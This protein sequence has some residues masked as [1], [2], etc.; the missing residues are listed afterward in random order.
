MFDRVCVCECGGERGV[1]CP[2][3]LMTDASIFV[4]MGIAKRAI[5]KHSRTQNTHTH[6]QKPR[7]YRCCCSL[8]TNILKHTS[9]YTHTETRIHTRNTE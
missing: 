9:T 1:K 8:A 5:T 3:W 4:G 2:I 7:L 6:A